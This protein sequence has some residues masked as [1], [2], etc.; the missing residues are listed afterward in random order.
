MNILNANLKNR[1]SKDYEKKRLEA[2]HAYNV[3][4][5]FAEKDFD[6]IT[7][8]AA[9]LCKAP[10]CLI[11]LVD[12]DR[13]WFKS[14]HGI[15]IR[16]TSRD[17]SFCGKA[18]EVSS[19]PFEVKNSSVDIRFKGNPLVIGEPFITYYF[20][21]PLI[22]PDGYPLGTLCIIDHKERS[23]TDRQKFA[24]NA[25]AKQVVNLLELRRK[26][27]KINNLLANMFPISKLK[28]ISNEG[29]ISAKPYDKCTVVFTDFKGFTDF[30]S[31]RTA[32]EVVNELHY[33]YSNFDSI[34][35]FNKVEKIKTIG[36]AYMACAGIDT[37]S[38][39]PALDAIKSA[40]EIIDFMKSYEEEC[41][42]QNK[43]PLKI[44]IGINTGPIISGVVGIK[45]Y[46][47][48]IWGNT[49]NV[50]S[51]IETAGEIGRINI[52]RSTYEEIKGVYDVEARGFIPV[53]NND[54]LEMYFVA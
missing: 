31:K 53:K 50:A 7:N 1:N 34:F 38:T 25:L 51:H 13:Q 42:A 11:S 18:I 15:G 19:E 41:L 49:V 27:A 32:K 5:S 24:L 29:T 12:K 6:D 43:D 8:V 10:I 23:L 40:L 17:I 3:L 33:L 47:F 14:N 37:N 21:I 46:S 52:S 28:E 2:L 20:G 16:E 44:R 48:D 54:E 4:D 35:Y 9:D 45:K 36:D 26:N 22:N 39:N 30:S